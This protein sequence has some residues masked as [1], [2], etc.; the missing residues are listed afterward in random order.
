MDLQ[1]EFLIKTP[2]EKDIKKYQNYLLKKLEGTNAKNESKV[3]KE[4]TIKYLN[5]LDSKNE[6][7]K[8][9][10]WVVFFD[11]SGD[12]N[13]D[14]RVNSVEVIKCKTKFQ[15][16]LLY[17]MKDG[18]INLSCINI[19]PIKRYGVDNLINKPKKSDLNYGTIFS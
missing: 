11:F 19:F 8:E 10:N 2:F 18:N 17:C 13:D 15:A 6:N 16:I 3:I 5:K 9:K 1:T 12:R 7:K 4:A 14:R